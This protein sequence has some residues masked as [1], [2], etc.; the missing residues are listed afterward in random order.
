MEPGAR[1]SGP[2][3]A[4]HPP[5]ILAL[6]VGTSSCRA[7]VYD[8]S[9]RAIPR[10]GARVAYAPRTTRDGGAE[11][12]AD[13]LLERVASTIDAVLR[14]TDGLRGVTAVATATFWHSPLGLDAEG[15]PITPVYLWMDA[16]SRGAADELRAR[17]DEV[18]VHART[19]CVLHWS[20]W[21]AK[22]QWLER[23]RPETFKRVAR[24]VSFGEYVA[25]R[26]FGSA[27]VSV[28]MASGT[29][30]LDQHTCV[31]D[32][33][34]LA[35]L[36]VREEQLSP[37][38]PL[39]RPFVGL[40]EPFASRWP[41]LARV[42]WLPAVGDGACSNLGADCTTRDRF[43]LMIGTSGAERA[44]WRA[45]DFT[46]PP[47]I[48]CYRVDDR[49]VVMGGALN[50]GGSLFDW[51]RGSLRLPAVARAEATLSAMVPDAHGLTVLPFWAGERSP[52]FA[53]DARG[54]IV[55]LRLHTQP[56]D[57]LRAALEAV[58][59]H[60]AKIDGHLR[61]AVPEAREV[62]ATGGALLRSPAWLQI[63]S[64]VLGRPVLAST[65]LQASSRGA[66]L[67]ALEVVGSLPCPLEELRPSASRVYEPVPAHVERYR[68]AAARQQRLYD[69]LVAG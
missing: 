49:R 18:T 51:M 17:L 2:L 27:A 7:S 32:R 26:L 6:D 3:S 64:D 47:G 11:L 50:D 44:A 61:E 28:S 52:G 63:V 4:R 69:L 22:L 24:W 10:V 31:W 20:Y 34:L 25:L 56:I 65:E 48:W 54:A 35:E 9:T 66:A 43:A 33:P 30:L 37:I 15:C 53:P 59:L 46:I 21:P 58:A 8:A 45:D 13:E 40:R 67:L 19:G 14:Q 36:P 38:V 62:V 55:G 1:S 5:L 68:A 60:F 16:R 12:D 39:D 29:G 41:T 23:T 57:M 42:P